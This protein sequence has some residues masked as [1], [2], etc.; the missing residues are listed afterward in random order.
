MTVAQLGGAVQDAY[1]IVQ[2]LAI[3]AGVVIGLVIFVWAASVGMRLLGIGPDPGPY[4][5]RAAGV[6]AHNWAGDVNIPNSLKPSPPMPMTAGGNP[7]NV[8][9]RFRHS[10]WSPLGVRE[11]AQAL[12]TS[13][14]VETASSA[15]LQMRIAGEVP[16][17]RAITYNYGTW[18]EPDVRRTNAPIPLGPSSDL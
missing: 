1:T 3:P 2:E 15:V 17:E 4:S 18:D 7:Y 13:R 6:N 16:T 8:R 10:A 12:A 9:T 14:D 5:A 11:R